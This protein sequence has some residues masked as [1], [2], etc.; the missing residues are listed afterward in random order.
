[1]L[2]TVAI[3]LAIIWGDRAIESKLMGRRTT[4]SR[5]PS[6]LGQTRY[7]QDRPQPRLVT[8]VALPVERTDFSVDFVAVFDLRHHS[9]IRVLRGSGV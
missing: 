1:M 2:W 8:P 7:N 9:W 3:I 5:F 4:P 6:P